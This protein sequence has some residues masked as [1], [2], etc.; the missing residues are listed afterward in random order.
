MNTNHRPRTVLRLLAASLVVSC[1]LAPRAV[2]AGAAGDGDGAP[3]APPAPPS[4]PAL[5]PRDFL[6]PPP[7]PPA[8]APLLPAAPRPK[9][10]VVK[11]RKDSRAAAA[12]D[13]ATGNAKAKGKR[14]DGEHE[15]QALLKRHGVKSSEAVFARAKR[16]RAAEQARAKAG[17]D[18]KADKQTRRDQLF[19]WCRIEVPEG[20]DEARMLAD[21]QANPA[22]ELAEPVIEY[23]LSD[24]DPPISGL[25]DTTTDPMIS[26]QFHHGMIKSQAAWNYLK[27]NGVPMGG[28]SDVVVAVIDTGT[29]YNHPELVA[30][31]WTNPGE[32][33]GNGIDD[34]GNGFIDD[35]HGCS[36]TS[37]PRSHSGDPIDLHGHGTHVAGIIAATAFNQMGGAGVAFGVKIMPIRAAHY[38]GAMTSTDISEGILYAVDNGAE[39]INMSFGGPQR[40][41][42]MADA[43][44]VA[45]SQAA[46]VAAAGNDGSMTPMYP[47]SFHYVIGVKS[48]DGDGRLS[49]FSNRLGDVMAPGES[50]LSTLPGENYAAWS[51]TSMATPMVS[52]VAALMRSYFWM[53]D[54]WSSRFIMGSIVNSAA[55]EG[56][57]GIVDAYV[58]LTEPPQPGVTVLDT[59]IF[60]NKSI[61]PANDADGRVDSG[62]TIHLAVEL[63]NRAGE[64]E[65]VWGYLEAWAEGAALPDPYVTVTVPEIEYGNI[66]PFATSDN[67]FIYDS[68]GVIT[69]VQEPFVFTVSPDCP[70]EHVIEFEL[71]TVFYDGW[72]WENPGPFERISRFRYVVQR[73]RNIPTVISEDTELTA[74]QYWIVGGPVL[75]EA[76]ATLTVRPGTQIQWGAISSD[77]YNPG[78]QTGNMVVRGNLRVEGTCESPVAM[79]PSYMVNGQRVNINVETGGTA[80][81]AYAKIR[82]PNITN[83]RNI[84][85]AYFD[86]DLFQSNITASIIKN[87]TFHKLRGGGSLKAD[88]FERCLFDA[89]WLAPKNI[90]NT[91]PS[92]S[93]CV[94]LQDNE[95]NH[96]ISITP[97]INIDARTFGGVYLSDSQPLN[98]ANWR[99]F[100]HAVVLGGFTYVSLPV[101]NGGQLLEADLLAQHFGGHV[102]SVA[103]TH[104]QQFLEG[105]VSENTGQTWVAPPCTYGIGLTDDYTPGVYRWL[106]GSPLDYFN[107]NAGYPVFL[108]PLSKRLV[109]ISN[110][111]AHLFPDAQRGPVWNGPWRN[112]GSISAYRENR[113]YWNGLAFIIKIPGAWNLEDLNA[114]V[115]NDNALAFVRPRLLSD[116]RYNAFLNKYWDPNIN[117][118]MRVLASGYPDAY[119]SM[120]FN[121]WGTT[122][123]TLIDHMIVDYYDNFNSPHVDYQPPAPHGYPTTYPFVEQVLLNGTPVES[124]PKFGTERVD[125]TVR[126]NRDMNMTVEPF[127]TFGPSPPH[128]DF[129]VVARDENFHEVACGW[130]D[131]RTW[132]GSAWITPMSGDGYHLMRISGAV[133]ADDPWLVSGYDVGRFR[134]EVRSM[135]LAAMTLQAHGLEGA[136]RLI[137][138][139]DDFDLLAGYNLYRA[140]SATGPAPPGPGPSSTTR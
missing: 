19:R 75:V 96:P 91:T 25:P 139:Q 69:G 60:D 83:F 26:Q 52:G 33:P 62:E 111:G 132:Q 4:V 49:W 5:V 13:Q 82:N 34:D 53:R 2:T 20:A 14:L 68:Q 58:A 12:F 41:Q 44:Q 131:A 6:Q 85:H 109:A 32:I 29:D 73:G 112:L 122:S 11:L 16:D 116:V 138:Q 94:F 81:I 9:E 7:A 120:N 65:A 135:E 64:A 76:G 123:T 66:G 38:S 98:P 133:A 67:G 77:P 46:L 1:V 106:D 103:D 61:D 40:S 87:S 35:I 117:T 27:Q 43:L 48:C 125:F 119:S 39:V 114:E 136:I 31:I 84:D 124:V 23:Q 93:N 140:T 99:G 15:L 113:L 37:D 121:Y 130:L 10:I 105:Y 50:I 126:F 78:P 3:A 88:M 47:A 42:I 107:W 90:I 137:W 24:I 56:R 108:S 45:L 59:W 51:G 30:N 21:L 18:D 71:T 22:V 57:N 118:W 36:V 86:W 80:D 55:G 134:F 115:A 28:Y 97:P 127:V 79:F 95:N 102:T 70:N 92:L 8:A 89:G 63:M 54:I 17:K 72:N 129:Q 110:S 101:E 74:D 100:Y 128:T 104:E